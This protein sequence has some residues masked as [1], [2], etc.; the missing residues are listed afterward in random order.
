MFLFTSRIR[1]V[2]SQTFL[3][4]IINFSVP[5]Y[6]SYHICPKTNIF[7][8]N[9]QFYKF[10]HVNNTRFIFLDSLR[11]H[12]HLEICVPIELAGGPPHK[13]P[14]Q[15]PL[16]LELLAGSQRGARR[17]RA[18]PSRTFPLYQLPHSSP[19]PCS[20]RCF[21]FIDRRIHVAGGHIHMNMA[22]SPRGFPNPRGGDRIRMAG[23][24][25]LLP[26][27]APRPG[28]WLVGVAAHAHFPWQHGHDNR[29]PLFCHIAV[30]GEGG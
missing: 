22:R 17:A 13:Q 20:G 27:R 19:L 14:F 26:S 11:R 8:F 3:V 4:L 23:G 6:I 28:R 12:E 7:S 1:F 9:H 24:W 21:G 16:P 15:T 25:L 2:R 30:I 10:I 18:G 5:F 29:L